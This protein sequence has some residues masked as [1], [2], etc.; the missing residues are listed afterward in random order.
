MKNDRIVNDSQLDYNK[1]LERCRKGEK[2]L[3][4][5]SIPLQERETRIPD[6]KNIV[7]KLNGILFD[8]EN[9]GIMVT[10]RQILEGFGGD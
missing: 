4:D 1:L 7:D 3:N 8:M 2:Y 10:E 6:F 9:Q 5:S